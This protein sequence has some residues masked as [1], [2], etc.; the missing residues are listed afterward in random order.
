M[1]YNVSLK[2][3]YNILYN[4]IYN[5]QTLYNIDYIISIFGHKYFSYVSYND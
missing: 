1:I 2:F 4:I 5:I 3:S